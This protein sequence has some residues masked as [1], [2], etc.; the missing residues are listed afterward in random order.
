MGKPITTNFAAYNCERGRDELKDKATAICRKCSQVLKNTSKSRL[1]AHFNI[2]GI[3]EE[4]SDDADL[5][6]D[7][8]TTQ[9]SVQT[10]RSPTSS[11]KLL[12][13]EVSAESLSQMSS[14][15]GSSKSISNEPKRNSLAYVPKMHKFA[16]LC[17]PK[18]AKQIVSK[19]IIFFIEVGLDFEKR[20]LKSFVTFI[21]TMRPGLTKLLPTDED[22][23]SIIDDLYSKIIDLNAKDLR[24]CCLKLMFKG[25]D[26][27]VVCGEKAFVGK[28]EVGEHTSIAENLET[29]VSFSKIETL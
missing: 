18:D 8:Q 19:M 4:D 14:C 25:S 13:E 21:N 9:Q 7:H 10:G 3:A 23:N 2:C 28:F 20:N 29:Y 24:D 26:C 12:S 17:T 15:S 11:D 16:D 6:S 22:L 5:E 27:Y 1:Q